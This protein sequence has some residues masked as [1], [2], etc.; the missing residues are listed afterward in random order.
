MSD[1]NCYILGQHT[2]A[3]ADTENNFTFTG[4]PTGYDVIEIHAAGGFTRDDVSR[5][6]M[7]S[8]CSW[9]GNNKYGYAWRGSN[10]NPIYAG[11]V[12]VSPDN[13]VSDLN[14]KA[15]G[16]RFLLMGPSSQCPKLVY[17]MGTMADNYSSSY[18]RFVSGA[19]GLDI[20][21]NS[22]IRDWGKGP[23]RIMRMRLTNIGTYSS[24]SSP[25]FTEGTEFTMLGYKGLGEGW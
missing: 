18:T 1:N 22:T 25:T 10:A 23:W 5:N 15:F 13:T 12:P 11:Y 21:R 6:Y 7:S 19:F 14:H 16:Y 3:A 17:F 2:V 4:I 9:Y 20:Q 24:T 8:Y